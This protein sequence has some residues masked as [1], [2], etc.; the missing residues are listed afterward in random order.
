M[1]KAWRSCS[2]SSLNSDLHSIACGVVDALASYADKLRSPNLRQS[3]WSTRRSARFVSTAI[4]VGWYT[5]RWLAF[6]SRLS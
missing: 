6:P 2:N 1:A 5:T 4:A 3:A